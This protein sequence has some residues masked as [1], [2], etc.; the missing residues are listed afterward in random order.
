[1][2]FVLDLLLLVIVLTTVIRCTTRG[3]VKSVVHLVSI[4]AALVVAYSFTPQLAGWLETEVLADRITETVADSIRSLAAK[5]SEGFDLSRLFADMPADFTALLER[6]GADPEALAAR[7]GDM[8]AVNAAAADSMARAIAEPVVSGLAN[9]CAFVAL[10]VGA[11]LVCTLAGAL[12]GLIVKLP[13]LRTANRFLGFLLGLLCAALLAWGFAEAAELVMG[14]LH[15]VDP[16]TFDADIIE[17]T[18]IVKHLCRMLL[19]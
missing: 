1:M 8:S 9:V 4:V 10:F 7:F 13:V 11:M 19:P 5:G 15:S 6:F 12:L 3:F 2:N 17:H 14:Y 16:A 18:L